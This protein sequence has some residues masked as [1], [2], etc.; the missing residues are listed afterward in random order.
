[1]DIAPHTKFCGQCFELPGFI[2]TDNK[3][4]CIPAQCFRQ[5]GERANRAID[6]FAGKVRTDL[7]QKILL[8]VDT[9][10]LPVNGPTAG[11]LLTVFSIR[12]DAR[13]K[14]MKALGLSMIMLLE[15]GDLL[16]SEH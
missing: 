1:M 2:L 5:C 16:V 10:F 11:N 4:L 7:Q 3:Q 9:I 13:R 6:T 15:I 14:N 12:I 8:V